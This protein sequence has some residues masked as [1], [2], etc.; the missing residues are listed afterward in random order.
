MNRK[1]F[2]QEKDEKGKI[3]DVITRIKDNDTLNKEKL[4]QA[5]LSA[6]LNEVTENVSF[7]NN[8]E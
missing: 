2:D 7:T 6:G 1:L 5:F 4:Y 8:E 3:E